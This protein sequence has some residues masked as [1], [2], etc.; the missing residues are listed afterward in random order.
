MEENA[1]KRVYAGY[2]TRWDKKRIYVVRVVK[3]ID[4]GEEIVI[5]KDA[6][7]SKKDNEDYYTI[8]K[9]SFCEQVEADGILRD[10]YVRQ[11]REEIDR[12]MVL[13][14][15]EDGFEGP[16]RKPFTYHDN[17]YADRY[18]RHCSSYHEYAKDICANYRLDQKRRKLINERRQYIGV[19]GKAD[20]SAM[21]EDISFLHQS[22]KT[23]LSDHIEIF[24][25][26]FAKG[27]SVRK[28]AEELQVNRGVIERRQA[29]LI[30]AF[31]RLLHERDQADGTCRLYRK[32]EVPEEEDETE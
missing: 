5:C 9:A 17:E 16:K 10:K 7:F 27:L 13:E 24:Q 31:S 19:S 29:A 32:P 6:S 8:T 14:V 3:D 30:D 1:L 12:N 15:E 28:A 2:Y 23:V 20:Y 22:L 21:C 4:T 11:T 26:R 25:T 18:I